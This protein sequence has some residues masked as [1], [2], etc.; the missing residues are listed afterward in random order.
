[1]RCETAHHEFVISGAPTMGGNNR[2]VDPAES[3]LAAV[4]A[5][6]LVIAQ[7]FA[8]L[9]GIRLK[10]ISVDVLGDFDD[11]GFEFLKQENK[12][13]KV[14]FSKITM[15]YTIESDNPQDEIEEFIRFVEGN[16]PV[17]DTLENP[18]VYERE[19][20]LAQPV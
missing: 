16:C 4:G 2:G 15:K 7:S 1:M 20:V 6:A 19:V 17:L 8:P 5:C 9:K 10:S 11:Y 14:G 18:P 12:A 13:S 3:L